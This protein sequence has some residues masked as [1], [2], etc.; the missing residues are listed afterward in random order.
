VWDYPTDS[1]VRAPALIIEQSVFVATT[2]GRIHAI[3]LQSGDLLW[4]YPAAEAEATDPEEAPSFNTA[5]AF[6]DGVVYVT[7]REGSL[8]AVDAA[9]GE[10][11]CPRPID[12]NGTVNIYP[13]ISDGVVFVGLENPSGIHAFAAGACGNAPSGYSAFYPSSLAVRLGLLATPDTMYVL[14]DRLLLAMLLDGTLWL[15]AAGSTPSPWDGGPFGAADIITTPPV[16]ADGVLYVGSQDG[17]VHAVDAE[18]GI[19]LWQFNAESAI[20]G[21]LVVVPGTVVVTTA[22]GEIIAIAGQ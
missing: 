15:D 14:E 8:H 6:F 20:R 16:L 11:L 18:S 19:V 5:P 3:D 7:S 13:S 10:P 12:L 4:R 9:S 22:A 17:M 21:E 1:T 2:D